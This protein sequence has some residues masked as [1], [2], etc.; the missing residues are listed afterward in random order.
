M[1]LSKSKHTCGIQID[2]S[3]GL[4]NQL[5]QFA[6]GISMG[7]QT[8]RSVLFSDHNY[9]FDPLRKYEL[10]RFDI[11]PNVGYCVQLSENSLE[12][13]PSDICNCKGEIIQE[14]NFHFENYAYSNQ[15]QILRGYWQSEE[16]FHEFRNNIRKYISDFILPSNDNYYTAIHF[17]LGDMALIPEVRAKHGILDTTYYI[18]ALKLLPEKTK[19]VIYMSDSRELVLDMHISKLQGIFTE[20]EF[21]EAP[22]F[23]EIA[24]LRTIMSAR[25][26]VMANSTFSWWGAYLN[27]SGFVI[28]PRNVFSADTLR[29]INICD[30]YPKK[31]TLI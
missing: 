4:G 9:K 10:S 21:I 3:G 12:F 14:R 2:L 7:I 27:N 11:K 1:R 22:A 28:A 8:G 19:K 15:R 24:D 26:V 23:G 20:L 13:N 17:R 31:F 6:R 18:R 5:F 25:N 30:Y 16:Y 29:Q